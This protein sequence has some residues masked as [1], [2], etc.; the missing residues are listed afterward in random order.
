MRKV[1]LVFGQTIMPYPI[2]VAGENLATRIECDVSSVLATVPDAFFAVVIARADGATYVAAANL[3]AVDGILTYVLTSTDTAAPGNLGIEIQ[4]SAGEAVVKSW[5]YTFVIAR[6][7]ID[8]EPPEASGPD[9]VRRLIEAAEDSAKRAEEAD[10]RVQAALSEY[11]Y[12]FGYIVDE[13]E[14]E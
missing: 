12:D 5:T 11:S 10:Q 1:N 14:D 6:G 8:G 3:A 7:L 9:W 13:P 2:G 4:A